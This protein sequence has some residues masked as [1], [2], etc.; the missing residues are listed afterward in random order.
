MKNSREELD[1]EVQ[2]R[3]VVEK[4]TGALKLDKEHLSKE[5]KE[6]LKARDSAE[7]GLKTTT[8][9]AEDMRQ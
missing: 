5:V 8:K 6:A 9:Q 4:A 1:A 7:A 3:L 2:S